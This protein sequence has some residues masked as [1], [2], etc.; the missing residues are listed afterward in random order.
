MPRRKRID[1]RSDYGL[2][3]A[4]VDALLIGGRNRRAGSSFSTTT[5]IARW[6]SGSATVIGS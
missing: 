4:E 5:G 1:K 6:T 2:T 3:R